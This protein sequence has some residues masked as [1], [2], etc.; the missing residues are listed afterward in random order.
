MK[1]FNLTAQENKNFSLVG[2]NLFSVG[3][4]NS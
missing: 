2:K 3:N 4:A 1:S